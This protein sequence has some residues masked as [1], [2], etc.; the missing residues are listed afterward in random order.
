MVEQ[1][2]MRNPWVLS[3]D[4][5]REFP[6]KLRIVVHERRIETLRSEERSR[7]T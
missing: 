2:I 6:D 3:V 5:H 1:N 4:I 7:G